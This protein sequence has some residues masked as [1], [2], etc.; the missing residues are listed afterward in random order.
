MLQVQ[1]PEDGVVT[2]SADT[3]APAGLEVRLML[4]QDRPE[5]EV[6]VQV[7]EELPEQQLRGF[8]VEDDVVVDIE[9]VDEDGMILSLGEG[10][11]A[12]V[13]LPLVPPESRGRRVY[14]YD[15]DATPPAWV[16]LAEPSEGSPEGLVCGVTEHFSLFALGAGGVNSAVAA[17]VA[18]AFR[19]DGGGPGDGCDKR[20]SG[21]RV[22]V[23]VAVDTGPVGVMGRS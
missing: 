21:G 5:S 15:D 1:V 11:S 22:V 4:P 9:L 10:E 23:G 8:R 17:G 3:S 12:V 13:C 20:S 6:F 14:R 2:V 16:A 18:G 7:V 19:A